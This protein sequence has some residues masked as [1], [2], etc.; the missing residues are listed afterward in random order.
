[1][2]LIVELIRWCLFIPLLVL[3]IPVALISVFWPY[4]FSHFWGAWVS[5][6]IGY[7]EEMRKKR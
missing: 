7:E 5:M 3:I 2:R 6:S 4:L 1:M